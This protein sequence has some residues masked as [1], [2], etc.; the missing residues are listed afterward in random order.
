[1]AYF[2]EVIN[3]IGIYA[4]LAMSLN[5]ICGMTGLLQLGHAGFF[6]IG[7]YTSGLYSIYMFNPEIGF[8]NFVI[9]TII[10]IFCAI[11]FS[12]AIGVPC[13]RLSGDYLAIATLGAGEIIRL[14][15]INV[16][17]P[18]TANSFDE[19]FGGS[20][21][22][23]LPLGSDFIHSEKPLPRDSNW[24]DS[25]VFFAQNT[26]IILL[27][28]TVTFILLLN[29]KR[30]AIGRA[31]LAI[32]ED[33]IAAKSMGVNLPLYKLLS[34]MLSASFAALAGA[35]FVH[36]NQI[37]SPDDFTLLQ[38]ITILLIVV[39]GGMGSFTG[40]ILAAIVLIS[41]PELL[42]FLPRIGGAEGFSLAEKKELIFAFLLVLFVRL[43]PN[44]IMGMKE[45]YQIPQ[46][47]KSKKKGYK[48]G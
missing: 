1:M 24:L 3:L 46:M 39:L 6:A 35:L 19:P 45:F 44:G 48:N 16:M 38:T 14:V 31:L 25:A 7:A 4:I 21:G 32:R 42:R 28:A 26:W 40:S 9:G 34:F 43:T 30:S 23:T 2:I 12:L 17:F 41:I 36:M 47:F 15:L 29:I 18:A 11:L 22:I 8:L 5:V 20:T 33:E 10:A 37:V 27:F 13:L